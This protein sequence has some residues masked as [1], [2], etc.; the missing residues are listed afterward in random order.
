MK[1]AA[2]Y[3]ILAVLLAVLL[4]AQTRWLRSAGMLLAALSLAMIVLSII[5]ADFD[6]TFAAILGDSPLIQQ[7]TPA[8]LNIQ[9]VIASAAMLFLCWSAWKQTLRPAVPPLALLNTHAAYGR[10]SRY[11]HWS[12]ATLMFCLVPIGLFMTILPVDQLE[13]Q[14]FAAAHQSLGIT[15]LALFV[16]RVLWLLVSPPPGAETDTPAW[17]H[18]AARAVHLVL[19]ASLVA[20]PLSGYLLSAAGDVPIDFYAPPLPGIIRPGNSAASIAGLI[21]DWLLPILFCAAIALHVGAVL[22]H[23]FRDGQKNTVRRMLR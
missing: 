4:N 14:G 5:L 8:I 13:R 6:G 2:W 19:Y 20:F 16:L 10:V 12:I 23:H 21:H 3:V 17:Q 15:V 1:M 7:W 11:L 18:Q 22:K 9:A